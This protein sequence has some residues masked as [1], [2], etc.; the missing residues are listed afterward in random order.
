VEGAVL[1]PAADQVSLLL[2][3]ADRVFE[4]AAYR[5]HFFATLRAWTNRRATHRDWAKLNLVIAHSTEPALW[6]QEL[7]QSPF[8]VGYRFKL[9][10]L[11]PAEVHDL[12]A[13]YGGVLGDPELEALYELIG[14]QPSSC[15]RPSTRCGRRAG[16]GASWPAGRSPWTGPS[17][18]GAD[19]F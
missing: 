12:N 2:D 14:G 13:R 8:N 1:K 17:A 9:R 6:I 19:L 15:A 18:T 10:D 16:P 5:D 7:N 11:G 4:H 3:E